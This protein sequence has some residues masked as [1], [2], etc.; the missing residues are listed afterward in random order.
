MLNEIQKIK[1][2]LLRMERTGSLFCSLDDSKLTD[3][4][5]HYTARIP[6]IDV[7]HRKYVG[8]GIRTAANMQDVYLDAIDDDIAA[9]EEEWLPERYTD[10][11]LFA[12]WDE[13]SEQ[14]E[15]VIIPSAELSDWGFDDNEDTHGTL[16]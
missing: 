13:N 3:L 5:K 11:K 9:L 8:I 16:I 14:F 6:R 2:R 12:Q 15:F 7:L 10:H 1:V 4:Q